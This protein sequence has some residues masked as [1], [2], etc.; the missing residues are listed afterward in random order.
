MN[1]LLLGSG[2]REHAIA[3]ALRKS[4]FLATLFAAPG[5]PGIAEIA[6]IVSLDLAD[7]AA[8]AAFCKLIGIG[9]VVVGP[10]APLVAGIVDDLAA[11]GVDCFGPSKAA[12]QLEGSK[13]FTKEFCARHGI[14]TARHA[15]FSDEAPARDYVRAMSLPIVIKADG[16]A[17]GKGVVIA[18]TCAEADAAIGKMLSG[19]FGRAGERIV[20]EEFLVGE[21]VSFFAMCDGTRAVALPTAQDHKRAFDGDRGPNTGGMGSY[22][23]ARIVDVPMEARTL[24]EIVEPTLAGMAAEGTPFK[25]VLFA[26]L[27]ICSDGPKLVEYNVRLGDPEAQVILP[28][29]EEDFLAL[30][31]ACVEGTLTPRV[32]R[33]SDKTALSVVL[34]AKGYPD[35]PVTGT[36]IGGL[37][38]AAAMPDV[39]ITHAG[40]KLTE[41]RLLANGGRVLNVTALGCDVAEAR[42]RAYAAV[43]AIDWDGGFCRRDIGW[44]ALK[45]T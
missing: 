23:P 25:G 3:L 27:M 17:A 38:R 37:E 42:A 39:T 29:L 22:S 11:A 18:T 44:R 2:G 30:V 19:G 4:R 7:H 21:E 32:L 1:V 40:T 9:V 15:T 34:A 5:N 20:I 16:L 6:E 45:P 33:F 31:L 8:I 14:P 26:G 35:N 41:G 24:R 10:E 36:E 12:A 28:R 13:A 43:D